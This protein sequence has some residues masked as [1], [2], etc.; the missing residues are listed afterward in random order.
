VSRIDRAS[1]AIPAR[2]L[3]RPRT[4]Q[5]QEAGGGSFDAAL[6]M[7][8]LQLTTDKAAGS[9]NAAQVARLIAAGARMDTETLLSALG[10]AGSGS[11][12]DDLSALL[13]APR[14]KQ[15]FEALKPAF[16]QAERETGVP[17][18]VQA[19]QWALET[20]WGRATPKD[21]QTGRESYN[22]FGIKGAGPAGTVMAE[23]QE[24]IGGR[25]VRQVAGFRA[26]H[27]H[28]EA[29]T[30]HA[31]LLTTAHYAPAQTAGKDLKAWT[32]MLGPQ[33]LGYATD[34][35]YSQKLW[36]II[37]ENGWDKQ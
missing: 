14:K 18:Q 27:S 31:R 21:M 33:R 20:G 10:M 22:L 29:I 7:A 3:Q 34:P 15:G 2:D 12:G 24:F 35:Q 25:M 9:G 23:T 11:S 5:G 36:Q 16:L 26:Y 30:D 8:Q 1:N 32:E 4:T 19:A 6:A 13:M 28:A 17:W 37:S